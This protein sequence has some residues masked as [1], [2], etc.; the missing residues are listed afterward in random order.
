MLSKK[1]YDGLWQAYGTIIIMIITAHKA[2][3]ETRHPRHGARHV[4]RSH[5]NDTLHTPTHHHL[6]VTH[7]GDMN[8]DSNV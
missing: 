2:E 3:N 6:Q 7:K 8:I 1:H 4:R 5:D